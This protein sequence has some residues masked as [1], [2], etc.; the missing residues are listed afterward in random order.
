[1]FYVIFQSGF[2]ITYEKNSI[3]LVEHI[4]LLQ[5]DSFYISNPVGVYICLL[6]TNFKFDSLHW[7]QK[8]KIILKIIFIFFNSLRIKH[9]RVVNN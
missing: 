1:M 7:E 5:T 8:K 3:K 2:K 9:K 6:R 4:I